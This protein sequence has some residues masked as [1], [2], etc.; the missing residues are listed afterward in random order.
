MSSNSAL[1]IGPYK[2]KGKV[3]LAP[4]AGITDVPFR[5][6]CW[7]SG[8][9]GVTSEMVTSDFSLW[10]TQKS[11]K[12]LQIAGQPSPRSI[13]I[14]GAEP[15][16]MARCA[17]LCA[18]LG[19]E[20]IDINMGC[21]AKK[22]CKKAAGSALLQ[23]INLVNEI[24]TAAVKAVDIPVTLKYR[25]GWDPEHKN[26]VTIAKVAESCGIAALTLHGRTRACSYREKAEYETIAEVVAAVKL[27]VIANGDITSAEQ[28]KKVLDYT[29]AQAV[30]IGRSAQGRPWIFREINH[31]LDWGIKLAPPDLCEIYSIIMKHL[32]SL[33]DF[34]GCSLGARLARK[35]I[36]WYVA[37]LPWGDRFRERF[38]QLTY[39]ADQLA[40]AQDY[41]EHLIEGEVMAA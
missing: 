5:S 15:E 29:G 18:E 24:L 10:H 21:P 7:E 32:Y 22:V 11:K 17:S 16:L 6:L 36:T 8:A 37:S 23:N 19:A 28:A 20:I 2:L 40:S 12:R 31:F 13:Q 27:P 9:S 26:A 30:M 14:L 41:F 33:Y 35:H 39:P 3:V 34:Y 4:M 25:T 38:N 1:K